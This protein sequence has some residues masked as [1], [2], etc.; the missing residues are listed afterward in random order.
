[1]YV[2]SGTVRIYAVNSS[3][4]ISC[5][6]VDLCLNFQRLALPLKDSRVVIT[7]YSYTE[8]SSIPAWIMQ[9]VVGRV[10]SDDE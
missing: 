10:E 8:L 4:M 2:N 3:G 5:V 6:N 7:V 1:M 9:V